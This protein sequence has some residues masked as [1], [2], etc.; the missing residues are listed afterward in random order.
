MPSLVRVRTCSY[1]VHTYTQILLIEFNTVL[2]TRIN[3]TLKNITLRRSSQI[4]PLILDTCVH[5]QTSPVPFPSH[6][7][8]SLYCNF[9]SNSARKKCRTGRKKGRIY[10]DRNII[11]MRTSLSLSLSRSGSWKKGRISSSFIHSKV[12]GGKRR[13]YIFHLCVQ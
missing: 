2:M 4:V 11:S 12:A 1:G 9:I 3:L 6:K 13:I 10:D 8:S 7:N 5:T